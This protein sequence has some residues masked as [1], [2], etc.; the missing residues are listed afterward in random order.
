M[1]GVTSLQQ[2]P[3]LHHAMP[4]SSHALDEDG[5]QSQLPTPTI[6]DQLD[7]VLGHSAH[8]EATPALTDSVDGVATM[9][10][11][12]QMAKQQALEL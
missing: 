4:S 9:W 7:E 12:L 8:V 6:F 1:P 5:G 3:A 2:L 10:G 11:Q